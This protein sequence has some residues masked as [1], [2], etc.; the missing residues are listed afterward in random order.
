[1]NYQN[2]PRQDKVVK[3]AFVPRPGHVFNLFDYAQIEPRLMAYFAAK[4]GDGRFAHDLRE[5]IDPYTA[6]LRHM[7]G[8]TMSEEQRQEGK[9]LFMSLLF[10]GGVRT[11][12]K[13]LGLKEK[14]ARGL[15]NDF[16]KALPVV[17]KLQNGVASTAL[18]RGYI[19]TPWGRHLHPEL[20]GEHKLLSAL[21]QGSAAHLAKRALNLLDDWLQASPEV[22]SLMLSF[23]H[24]EVAFDGPPQE[25]ALLHERVTELMTLEAPTAQITDIVPIKVGHEVCVHDLSDKRPYDE[26]KG[27][28]I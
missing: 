6:I 25:V 24:D 4:A 13:Q 15:I 18:R 20:H 8:D 26:W 9:R 7:Y 19:R 16:H 17:R 14:D 3:R 23:V 27:I 5:G 12:G 2:L 21:I 22:R 1:M 11:V 28:P 10:G